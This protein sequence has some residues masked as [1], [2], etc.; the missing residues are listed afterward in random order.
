[1]LN[2]C[3]TIDMVLVPITISPA[4]N[5]GPLFGQSIDNW[6]N[7]ERFALILIPETIGDVLEIDEKCNTVDFV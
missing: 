4:N 1:M 5:N 2:Q 3:S 7:L 6:V